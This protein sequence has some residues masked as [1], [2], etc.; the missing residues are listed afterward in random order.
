MPT[1]HA[2]LARATSRGRLLRLIATL[3]IAIV[4][5]PTA[6]RGALPKVA[7]G[8]KIRLVAAVPA[9]EFPCQI[10]TAP[11]G[12]LYVAEDPMDQIGPYEADNGRILVFRDGKEPV[13]FAE[14]FR[15][16]FGMAWR[17]GALY[18][19]NM[20]RLTVLRDTDGDGKAD[21]RKDIF[22]DLGPGPKGFNDHIVSGIQF[23]V[24]GR[25]YISVGD[26]GVPGVHGPDGR[27][28]Q[29]IGGGTIR[30]KPDGTELELFT[31]GTRNHLEPNLDA[32]D[33]LFTYDN[34]DDGG[35]WWT[36]VT[37]HIDGGFYG[38][39]YDY[40]TR[41]DRML[42]RM[43]EYGGGSPCGG[44]LYKED[45]WPAKFRGR[46]IWA[47][48]AKQ[49]VR[50]IAFEPE[51]ATF[52]VADVIELVEKGEVADF[53]PLDL[54]LSH[55]GAT[56]YIADWS[57]GGWANKA[58][59]LGRVYALTRKE[60]ETPTARGSDADAASAQL[61]RLEHPSFNERMRAQ[62]ALIR[63]AATDP[64]IL[65]LVVSALKSASTEPIAARHL[66]W[67][68]DAIAG[69]TPVG[70]SAVRA[71]LKSGSPDV[72]AQAAR[73]LGLRATK[74]ALDDLNAAASDPEPS[75]R[76]QALIALG[77]IG[78]SRAIPAIVASIASPDFFLAFAA[79]VALRRIDAWDVAARG[80]DSPDAKVRL[81]LLAAMEE[82]Y[83]QKAIETL[84]AYAKDPA[85][86]ADE[87]AKALGY[88][89]ENHR[90]PHPWDGSWW[91]TRPFLNKPPAKDVDWAGTEFVLVACRDAL[92]D[93]V[94]AIR[95]AAAG[96][97]RVTGDR[98]A[99]AAIR[100]RFGA[101]PDAGVQTEIARSLG[102]M[103]DA[104]GV[105]TLTLA[106]NNQATTA[107]VRDASLAAIKAIG[108]PK[109]TAAF[110][111]LLSKGTLEGSR[112]ALVAAALGNF[113]SPEARPALVGALANS[114]PAVRSAAVVALTALPGASPADIRPL[115]ADPDLGVKTA[116]IAASG[117]L[118]DVEA[119]PALIA[120]AGEDAT[121]F[122]AS[123]ALA[124][125]P[126]PR[127]IR[128]YVAGLS[129]K[130][131]DLRKASGLALV[132]IREKA[133]PVLDQFAARKEL[134]GVAVA[135]LRKA[136][137][138]GEPIKGWHIVGPFP[139][140]KDPEFPDDKAVDLTRKF[141]SATQTEV[142][143]IAPP[144]SSVND[145]GRINLAEA[146]GQR[147]DVTAFASAVIQSET[148]RPAQ[149]VL[150]ADDTLRVWLNG[151]EVFKSDRGRGN[152]EDEAERVDVT[153]EEGANRLLVRCGN[154]G[155]GWFFLAGLT[156]PS[157]YAFLKAPATGAFDPDTYRVFA[158]KSGGEPTR[159]RA[160]FSDLKGLACLKCHAVSGQGGAVGPELSGIAS[161][162]PRAELIASVLYPSARISSGYEPTVLALTDGKLVNGILKVESDD[163]LEIEDADAKRQRIPRDQIEERK[164]GDVSLMPSGL[165]EGLSREDFADLIAYLETLKEAPAAAK[166]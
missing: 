123:T 26:K 102:Q 83:S 147:D 152:S 118:K 3:A 24:D 89:A 15:P 156:R 1:P 92:S 8:F 57:M 138:R 63:V 58:E 134:S 50:A 116:A 85:R 98:A 81:A 69:A 17:D 55:D 101:E 158:E 66:V 42:P 62:A 16:I 13:V 32:A 43:A 90:K 44:V 67:I 95:M 59:K 165:A 11:D 100:A 103:G 65:S 23:G 93:P 163:A 124:S 113:K 160:L 48:W 34:T 73:A 106:L 97:V 105:P 60:P 56:L 91:G 80:L 4:G 77:R 37:H 52:R 166:P 164:V 144:A 18:V 79:R 159:G 70:E 9:V 141:Q 5:M 10:A 7:D 74:T 104:E 143:W 14:G 54:A 117:S 61:A 128:V 28:V 86:P 107:E 21:E 27:S 6:S 12:A 45:A 157:D 75:V 132:S 122:E 82:A 64:S 49:S 149:L 130:N 135:E 22:K 119:V 39:P 36:R 139:E 96:A 46:G 137:S 112:M 88:L 84:S 121:R 87:R 131:G 29:L 148:R 162:Y 110:V 126:D 140:K 53:R 2:P 153:L 161:K 145:R 150:L 151:Q 33:N 30:C 94:A 146:L 51:G 129:D 78:D 133:T 40:H 154:A 41:T 20:P 19:M 71:A 115:L 35:G 38:Y 109:A 108:G 99:L 72:C 111:E 25:L 114:D 155:G 120:L 68:V 47:E 31:S 127:A 142:G 125:L 76:L 136:F